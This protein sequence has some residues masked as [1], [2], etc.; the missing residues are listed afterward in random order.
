MIAILFA[1]ILLEVLGA[2]FVAVWIDRYRLKG[3]HN[4]NSERIQKTPS[5]SHD[6]E[7]FLGGDS[8]PLHRVLRLERERGREMQL[9]G[10]STLSISAWIRKNARKQINR[11][12][13]P[14]KR[15][16]R[17]SYD[18]VGGLGQVAGQVPIARVSSPQKTPTRARAIYSAPKPTSRYARLMRGLLEGPEDR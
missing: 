10:V 16:P 4:G 11:I 7:G 18:R 2:A 6:G 17:N 15:H 13:G 3:K 12:K 9:P 1:V 5:A 14:R 8:V